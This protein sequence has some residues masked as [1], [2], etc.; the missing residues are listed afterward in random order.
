M[1]GILADVSK[2]F[3]QSHPF[4]FGQEESGPN[5]LLAPPG[6]GEHKLLKL[7]RDLHL[8]INPS[9]EIF[10]P[11]LCRL[12]FTLH[13]FD[14]LTRVA[15]INGGSNNGK[16]YFAGMPKDGGGRRNLVRTLPSL[17]TL[18]APYPSHTSRA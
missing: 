10:T 14:N 9:S 7:S 5:F 8:R 2:R 11:T 17:E 13:F 12:A 18:N 4:Y 16:I 6:S 15:R 3:P 1:K